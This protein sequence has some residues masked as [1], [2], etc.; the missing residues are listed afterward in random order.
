MKRVPMML[1]FAC[2]VCLQAAAPAVAQDW[3]RG[4]TPAAAPP[5][6]QDSPQTVRAAIPPQAKPPAQTPT[7][8]RPADM[9]PQE[10]PQ[11]SR[12]GAEDAVNVRLDVVIT[13]QV[14]NTAPVKRSATVTV[15]DQ[16]RGS[17]R[18]GTQVAVPETQLSSAGAPVKPGDAGTPAPVTPMTRFQYRSV[19]LNVDANR[20]GIY[21]NKARLELSVEFSAIDE[22]SPDTGKPLVSPSFPT[23]SQNLT[24]VLENGKPLVIAQTSDV[25]DTV[26][27]KQS[28]EVTATILR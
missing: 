18:S 14:G 15:A 19:G 20:V 10:R 1:V 4:A 11:F 3:H 23:F 2:A 28:V 5:A 16:G 17:L 9:L 25:V 8:G 22:K 6:L 26:V 12:P 27:R 21:G 13:Y 7:P 24:L